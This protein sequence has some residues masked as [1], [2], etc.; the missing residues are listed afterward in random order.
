[1][2]AR[3]LSDTK[4]TP[5]QLSLRIRHPVIDPETISRTLTLEPEHCFK[6]GD[7]RA[8]RT[9]DGRK[10]QHTQTYWLAPIT[11]E[12]RAKPL[13]PTFLSA[14]AAGGRSRNRAES[15][16]LA[17]KVLLAAA[18]DQT[19][20]GIEVELLHFLRRLCQHHAFLQQIQ[21]EG[22]DVALL[23]VLQRDS[24]SDFTLPPSVTRMLAQLGIAIE[25]KFDS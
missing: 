5:I 4:A 14:I 24:A 1:M 8:A 13:D 23:M 3:K 18:R 11:T 17:D 2:Q 25:F 7:A 16:A 6:A 22:G 9:D 19:L 21:S 20:W 12:S 10:S 15:A